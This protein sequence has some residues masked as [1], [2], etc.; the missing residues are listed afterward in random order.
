M[1]SR[2]TTTQQRDAAVLTACAIGLTHDHAARRFGISSR[3]YRRHLTR[4]M[5]RL[6]AVHATQAVALAAAAGQLDLRHLHERTLPPWPGPT[7]P[8]PGSITP[9]QLNGSQP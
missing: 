3:T 1:V 9:A 7:R 6:G 2:P 5:G 8:R 4:A